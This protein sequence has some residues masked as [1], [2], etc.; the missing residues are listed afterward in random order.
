MLYLKLFTELGD[1]RIVEICTV[2]CND[3]LWYTVS[4]DQIVSNKSCHNVLGHSSKG[5]CLNLL[6]KVINYYQDETMPVG[7]NRYDLTNHIDAPHCK[8]PRNCQNIQR[9][10]H[11]ISIDLELVTGPRMLIR[12]D[13]HSGPI[14]SCPQDF[15]RHGMSTGVCSE[16]TFMQ[17]YHD[18]LCLSLIHTT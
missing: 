14:I 5:S 12:I 3:P 7:R 13:F 16:C 4:T 18:F 11:L 6:R 10:M 2:V 1:H 9:Y 8:R 17:F 15:L